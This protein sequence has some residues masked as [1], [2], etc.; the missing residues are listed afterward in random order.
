VTKGE[1]ERA[2]RN[3]GFVREE[4]SK[5]DFWTYSP[6]GS[7]KP[8]SVRLHK[9]SIIAPYV[10]GI[11]RRATREALD[12]Q[13]TVREA[14]RA[15]RNAAERERTAAFFAK[16]EAEQRKALEAKQEEQAPT[17]PPRITMPKIVSIT[18][19][20]IMT[21]DPTDEPLLEAI[22]RAVDD[23]TWIRDQLRAS[24]SRARM[25]L[26]GLKEAVKAL[27]HD[28]AEERAAIPA[29]KAAPR[30]ANAQLPDA[31]LDILIAKGK[32]NGPALRE[33]VSEKLG[34]DIPE[35]S[36][37]GALLSLRQSNLIISLGR[38]EG[39]APA[40]AAKEA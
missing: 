40:P 10:A 13:T 34:R 26:P 16:A 18:K 36:M 37:S 3:A 32:L 23:L 31:I 11:V 15:A 25:L 35:G 1:V 5:H 17:P 24:P 20:R 8:I 29:R 30:G 7:G 27:V 22:E 9:G 28:V 39:Y 19:E 12:D 33:A 4:Q 6:V 21:P 14:E 38:G 2:L